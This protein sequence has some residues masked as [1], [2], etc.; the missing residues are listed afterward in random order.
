MNR[1][2]VGYEKDERLALAIGIA[3]Q[4][5]MSYFPEHPMVIKM[6]YPM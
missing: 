5:L 2:D 6:N 4:R 3:S 1:A